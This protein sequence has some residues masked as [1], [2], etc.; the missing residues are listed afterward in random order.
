[1]HTHGMACTA[2]SG[3][4]TP[5]AL[6]WQVWRGGQLLRLIDAQR[7]RLP[8]TAFGEVSD[9]T[10]KR[11]PQHRPEP[12]LGI[13]VPVHLVQTITYMTSTRTVSRWKLGG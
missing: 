1:M 12:I 10:C 6:G 7:L 2:R 11:T 4:L 5:V 8:A 9:R 3:P 13:K